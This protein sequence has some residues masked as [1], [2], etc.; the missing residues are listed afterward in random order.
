MAKHMDSTIN[1]CYGFGSRSSLKVNYSPLL[2]Q[3]SP[4]EAG[5]SLYS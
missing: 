4:T 1:A 5:L 2:K 3:E